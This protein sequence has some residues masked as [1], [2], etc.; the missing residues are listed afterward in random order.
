VFPRKHVLLGLA[1]K[2]LFKCV[3]HAAVAGECDYEPGFISLCS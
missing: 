1:K 3:S 2:S